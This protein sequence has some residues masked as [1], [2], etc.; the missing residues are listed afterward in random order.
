MSRD[1]IHENEVGFQNTPKVNTSSRTI[2]LTHCNGV[3]AKKLKNVMIMYFVCLVKLYYEGF[4]Q[5]YFAQ[6]HVDS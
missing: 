4:L 1:N 6:I 2:T 5:S 3:K